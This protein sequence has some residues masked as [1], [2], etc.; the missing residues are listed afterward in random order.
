[1]PNTLCHVALQTPFSRILF[2]EGGF[3]FIVAG[4]II[5]DVPWIMQRI[6]FKLGCIDPY[7]LRLYFTVQASLLFCLLP[8]LGIALISR[9]PKAIFTLISFNCLLHLLL[10]ATQTKWANGVHL[11]APLNW[12]PLSFKLLW[13]EHMLWPTL[14]LAGFILF[15][16]VMIKN[17][18]IS[19]HSF[20]ITVGTFLI[21]TSLLLIYFA[22][23][24][25]FM[26]K[27]EQADS[28]FIQTLRQKDERAGKYIELDRLPYKGSSGTIRTFAGEPLT[29]VGLDEAT[30]NSDKILSVQ[31]IFTDISTIRVSNSHI[32]SG[33][34]DYASILGLFMACAL[35]LQ[36]LLI[37]HKNSPD[38]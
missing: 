26:G 3:L 35:A 16:Y 30:A 21:C 12:S 29:L 22:G 10:D 2:K 24:L 36:P 31:G 20:N 11:L 6:M 13:P 15:L 14:S 1:M 19:L 25:V 34:R 17:R 7:S 33:L 38:S 4:C 23:P 8:A 28:H 27:L 18:D 9:K 5:P 37:S 32:H